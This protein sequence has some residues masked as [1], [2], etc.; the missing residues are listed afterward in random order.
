MVVTTD[1]TEVL[2]VDKISRDSGMVGNEEFR[3][4]ELWSPEDTL[5]ETR[6]SRHARFR[7]NSVRPTARNVYTLDTL[8]GREML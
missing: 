8:P 1:D 4:Y 2:P 6:L 5:E 7:H 3:F